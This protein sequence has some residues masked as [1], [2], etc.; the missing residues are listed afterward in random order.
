VAFLSLLFGVCRERGMRRVLG[1]IV[2]LVR[3]GLGPE[4]QIGL[5]VR[6]EVVLVVRLLVDAGWPK[7]S[8]CLV[9]RWF[10]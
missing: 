4:G 8:L 9:G 2:A 1:G 5:V 6:F 10:A 3:G 7:R